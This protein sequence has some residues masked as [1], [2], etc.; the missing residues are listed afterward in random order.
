MSS[1]TLWRKAWNE[2]WLGKALLWWFVGFIWLTLKEKDPGATLIKASERFSLL[3]AILFVSAVLGAIAAIVW[4]LCSWLYKYRRELVF[5]LSQLIRRLL[6]VR[7]YVLLLVT[8]MV[9]A[10][11]YYFLVSLP[12][13]NRAVLA[14]EQERQTATRLAQGD[15]LVRRG[16][17]EMCMEQADS[18]YWRYGALNGTRRRD[19]TIGAPTRVWDQ[20]RQNKHLAIEEC[21]RR[22]AR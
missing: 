6:N 2:K 12:A 16:Q 20:A 15:D 8:I 4:R 14:M 17:L 3:V 19:G 13:H 10:V 1:G 9:V 18:A 5:L 7:N 22:Y 21:D 11:A